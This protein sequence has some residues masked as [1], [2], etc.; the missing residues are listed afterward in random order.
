MDAR[1]KVEAWEERGDAS[2]NAEA[3][4][5]EGTQAKTLGGYHSHFA[6][7]ALPVNIKKASLSNLRVYSMPSSAVGV[8]VKS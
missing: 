2:K 6:R 8:L 4:E 3:Q 5:E 1:K 7:H